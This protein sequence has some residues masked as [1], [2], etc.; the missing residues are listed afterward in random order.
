MSRWRLLRQ[1]TTRA[2]T[3]GMHLAITWMLVCGFPAAA[4]EQKPKSGRIIGQLKSQKNTPDGKNTFVE[5]LAPGEEQPRRY[6]VLYDAKIKGPIEPVL[7]AVRAAKVGDVVEFEW[8]QT[9][10]GPAIKSFKVFKQGPDGPGL[11]RLSWMTGS[12][13]E[14]K[15]GVDTEEHWIEPKG[16]MML[17]VGRT[18]RGGGKVAFEFMRIAST[19]NGISYFASPQG[20]PAHEFPMTQLEDKKVIFEDPNHGFPRRITYWLDGDGSLRARIEGTAQGEPRSREW[21][22]TKLT[23]AK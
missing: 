21:R 6:H 1:N 23:K 16:E 20:R 18:V 4:Q 3:T 22:W 10:H 2:R 14:R 12:W 11:D 17:G 7:A 8:V 5:V 19:P 9:G 15:E 13:L